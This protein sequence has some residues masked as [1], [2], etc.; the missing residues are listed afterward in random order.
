MYCALFRNIFLNN[1]I[2]VKRG[3][4]VGLEPLVL[5]LKFK[6]PPVYL[7]R[8]ELLIAFSEV[9]LMMAYCHLLDYLFSNSC[10]FVFV[11]YF[12]LLFPV[13]GQFHIFLLRLWRMVYLI[14]QKRGCFPSLCG[15]WNLLAPI[16]HGLSG[17][18][19]GLGLDFYL[20]Y[21]FVRDGGNLNFF[22]GSWLFLLDNC[23]LRR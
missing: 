10:Y 14:I 3:V 12:G 13:I 11:F 9:I 2:L 5:S 19:D 16:S 18:S 8:A 22:S 17:L 20:L 23:W 6:D 1:L 4:L 15:V 21:V 7:R